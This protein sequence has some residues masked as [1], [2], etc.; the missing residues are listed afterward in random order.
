MIDEKAIKTRV[1][2]YIRIGGS[3][4]CIKSCEEQ[5]VH[6]N[7]LAA[8]TPGWEIIDYYADLGPSSRTQPALKRLLAD[9]EAGRVDLIVTK[10]ISR[11][12]R[13]MPAMM[14]IA[15]KLAFSKPPVGL[16]F[17]D[18]GLNTRNRDG[19]LMLAMCEAMA[20]Q[21]GYNIPFA[22]FVKQMTRRKHEKRGEG[23]R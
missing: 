12:S 19:F 3:G 14:E 13:S 6:F 2:V 23:N 17:E 8:Q 4:D 10:S 11:I 1:A 7:L 9:C 16:Y 18:T 15:R 21:E 5:K 20:V 22:Q